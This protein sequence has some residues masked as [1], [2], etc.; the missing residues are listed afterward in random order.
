MYIQDNSRPVI[1]LVM[2]QQMGQL[3]F[4]TSF[5]INFILYCTS[6]QNFRREMVRMCTKRTSSTGRGG[7]LMQMANHGKQCGRH[8]T[9]QFHNIDI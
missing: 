7:T 6:G 8:L 9:T 3:L 2:A 4:N 5:G 1:W